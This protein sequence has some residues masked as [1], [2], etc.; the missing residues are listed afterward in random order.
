MDLD[1]AFDRIPRK[2]LEWAMGKKGIPEVLV[3]SV[4]SLCK[5]VDSGSSEELEV[6]VWMY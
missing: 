4:T 5:S 1:K 6:N 2:M 3:I